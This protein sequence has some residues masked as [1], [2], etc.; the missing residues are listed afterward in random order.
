MA[1]RPE[2]LAKTIDLTLVD[3][4]I[5]EGTLER[6][7]A[8]A[9]DHHFA[10]VCVLPEAVRP[11]KASL[12][13]SDVKVAATVAFP[14][15]DEPAKEKLSIAAECVEAGAGELDFVLNADA[16]VAGDFLLVRDELV[17]LVQVVRM[18][19]VNAG[20]AYVL[21]KAVFD[22][23]PLADKA[24]RFLCRIIDAA[25]IDFVSVVSNAN[26][27]AALHEVE[28]LR[29]YLSER[30]A[31]KVSGTAETAED[32][33]ALVNAG[34]GRIGTPHAVQ[35]MRDLATARSA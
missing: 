3:R 21:L 9:R 15:G 18:R 27:A 29:D 35:V 34:A 30:V 24:K 20:R 17:S 12:H 22:P 31:V 14:G 23:E 1:L 32:V 33:L 16:L 7:C 2:E 13:G 6:A 19:T 8:Q 25:G 5:G 26:G 11:A 4:T 10:S 28:L